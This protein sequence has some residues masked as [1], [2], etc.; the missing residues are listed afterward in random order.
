MLTVMVIIPNKPLRIYQPD[1]FI[2]KINTKEWVVQPK[3]DGHRALPFCTEAGKLTVMNR[4]G[5]PLTRA[6]DSFTWLSLL[7]IPR[8]WQLDGELTQSSRLIIWD[9]ATLG[10]KYIFDTPY[11]ERLK[12]LE[13]LIPNNL[14]KNNTSIEVIETLKASQYKRLLLK[15]GDPYLEGFVFKNSRATDLWGPYKTTEVPS[16]IKYRYDSKS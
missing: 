2:S 13:K 6:K 8:P 12:Q 15:R 16:Q 3:W 7:N 11:L 14:T 4:Q 5:T 10:G 1:E 9:I